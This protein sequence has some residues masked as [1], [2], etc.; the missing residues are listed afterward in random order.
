M[1]LQQNREEARR[2]RLVNRS[3][4]Q[5]RQLYFEDVRR[6]VVNVGSASVRRPL[7]VAGRVDDRFDG[8]FDS[9]QDHDGADH[10]AMTLI[11]KGGIVLTMLGMLVQF[12]EPLLAA[13]V[14]L[15]PSGLAG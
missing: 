14:A 10:S 7:R 6:G 4:A 11:V 8:G 13:A 12:R 9:A 3:V 15:L 5:H 1:N 2:R